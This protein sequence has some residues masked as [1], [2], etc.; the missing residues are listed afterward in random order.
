MTG[1]IEIERDNGG[2]GATVPPMTEKK[3]GLFA[4]YEL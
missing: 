1:A 2:D 3:V 4:Q